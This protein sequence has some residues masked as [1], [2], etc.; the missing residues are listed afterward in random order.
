ME[1]IN[2]RFVCCNC[3]A[4]AADELGGRDRVGRGSIAAAAAAAV[5]AAAGRLVA[6]ELSTAAAGHSDTAA[7]CEDGTVGN[8]VDSPA[9][10]TGH[11]A[12]RLG[13]LGSIEE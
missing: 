9:A 7:A 1:E 10:Q 6:A 8:D 12:G 2:R 11:A 5:V 13:R 3:Y 4:C